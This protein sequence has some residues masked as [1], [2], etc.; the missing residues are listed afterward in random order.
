MKTAAL[1]LAA[2][3]GKRMKSATPKVLHP[4]LGRPM[5]CYVVD[6]VTGLSPRKIVII[7]NSDPDPVRDVV[8]EDGIEYAVQ[9][10]QLG[11]GHAANS[12]RKILGKFRGNILVLN[13]DY[14]LITQ[15][16]LKRFLKSHEAGGSDLSVLTASVQDP[17]G[18]GR[19]I[20]DSGGLVVGIVEHGDADPGQRKINEINSGTYCVKSEFLW[21][22]LSRLKNTNSQGEYYLTDLV[23]IAASQNLK[24]SGYKTGD[25]DEVL[26]VNDRAQLHD[27]N[28][29]LRRRTNLSLMKRGVT[30]VGSDSVYISPTA[31]IGADTTVYPGTHIYGETVIGRGAVIGPSAWIENSRFGENVT[32]RAS[33]YI[34]ESSVGNDVTMGPFAH[35]RPETVVSDGAKIGNFVEIKK[36]RIGKGSKVPHLSYVGDAELGKDVNIGAGTITCNYDGVNKHRTTIGD[37]VFI[38]SDTMLVA[39]ITVGS[40][41]MT[42]AGSTITKDVPDGALAIGRARQTVIEK[43]KKKA[44]SAK[45]KK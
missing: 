12:A 41:A 43:W 13:G 35:L 3:L 38:G 42:G 33:C 40:G 1:I 10:E 32:V 18:Y 2:G 20:R 27:I 36:S 26:G 21:K 30:I 44:A 37:N 23:K 28:E 22:A 17:S 15:G 6:A 29:I 25:S 34:V 8:G 45:G 11:T 24:V 7:V 5:L 4:V 9:S 19:I 14:P 39:P 31:K 16:T